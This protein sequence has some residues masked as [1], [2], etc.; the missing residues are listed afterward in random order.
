MEISSILMMAGI[1]VLL[2][3]IY[4]YYFS[5]SSMLMSSVIAGNQITTIDVSKID[6]GLAGSVNFAY[7]LWFNINDWNYLYGRPKPLFRRQTA[8]AN[9][10]TPYA[11]FDSNT[12]NLLIDITCAGNT[13]TYTVSNIPIQK[14]VHLVISVYGKSLDVYLNGKL[15]NTFVLPG[16]PDVDKTQ[17]I[18][19]CPD[20]GFNGWVTKFEFWASSMDPQTAWNIYKSGNGSSIFNSLFGNYGVKLALLNNNVEQNSITI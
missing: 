15:V 20:G 19:I 16:V 14:W 7:S 17:Q 12:N 8:T 6:N 4:Y 5:S 10:F 3:I 1:F 18:V 2:Y 9:K 11:K 13:N